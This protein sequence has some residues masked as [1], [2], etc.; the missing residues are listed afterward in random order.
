MLCNLSIT[1]RSLEG[2]ER[3]PTISENFIDYLN[4]MIYIYTLS[5]LIK[6]EVEENCMN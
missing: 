1:W 5:E 4:L 6:K 2:S 3:L